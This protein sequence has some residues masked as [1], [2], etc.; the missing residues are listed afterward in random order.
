MGEYLHSRDTRRVINALFK[1]LKYR[2]KENGGVMESDI[3]KGGHL[4]FRYYPVVIWMRAEKS[5]L[6]ARVAKRIDQ[7]IDEQNGLQEAFQVFDLFKDQSPLD[8]EKG[9]L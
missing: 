8:F 7:M 1:V 3:Q 9:I 2:Y 4:K 5:V 6:E